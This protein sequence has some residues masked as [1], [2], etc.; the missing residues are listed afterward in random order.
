MK[1]L[2]L[3]LIGAMTLCTMQAQIVEQGEPALVYYSPKTTVAVEFA[4]IVES[5]EPGIYA[6]YAEEMIGASD[7][8]KERKQVFTLK[9]AQ[10]G[11]KTEADYS[12]PHKI[13][14]EAG[15]PMLLTIS[16]KGLLVGY[17]TGEMAKK[18]PNKTFDNK[19]K[20]KGQST[21][22]EVAPLPEEVLT[23]SNPL[24]QAHAVAKQIFHIRETRSYL[25]NGE[26]EHA[27][28]DGRSME[29]VLAELDKQEK[30]LTEL[31]VG[32][33]NKQAKHKTVYI[34]PNKEEKLLFFSEENGFTDADNIDADTIKVTLKADKQVYMAPNTDKKKKAPAVT[35]IV[36][37]LPGHSAVTVQYKGKRWAQRTLDIAQFGI[38]VP[39]SKELFVGGLPK[40]VFSEKSGNIQSI[41][42]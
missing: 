19:D 29:L 40:I 13:M 5:F 6:S 9:S 4:Y 36:Y 26:V 39:V 23:A 41:T 1:R 17:N 31:F 10:I 3:M 33:K 7:A 22:N 20:K 8:V 32:K 42:K 27:P 15:V 2:F 11:T 12:R 38:D 24:A 16:P 30:A 25:L 14:P 35:Q 34:D 28:A 18:E 37:N 21:K